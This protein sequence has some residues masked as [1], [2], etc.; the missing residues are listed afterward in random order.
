[1][2]PLVPGFPLSECLV[3]PGQGRD[4]EVPGWI[5]GFCC[6]AP[7]HSN[8]LRRVARRRRR[9]AK[10]SSVS[11]ARGQ[12]Y[13]N[14]PSASEEGT[15]DPRVTLSVRNSEVNFDPAF[16]AG[17]RCTSWRLLLG[18]ELAVGP[19]SGSARERGRNL[20]RGAGHPQRVP[21]QSEPRTV[22]DRSRR[23]GRRYDPADVHGE[24]DD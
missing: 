15:L 16:E 18:R 3:S 23:H 20:F 17:R 2:Q 4:E 19:S 22:Q 9:E 5:P 10:S 6:R 13:E 1:M 24:R 14:E 12:T 11:L 21:I 8:P 7:P